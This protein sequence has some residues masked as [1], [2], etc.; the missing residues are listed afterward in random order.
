MSLDPNKRLK[1]DRFWA[2]ATGF[3]SGWA[4]M[5]LLDEGAVRSGTTTRDGRDEGLTGLFGLLASATFFGSGLLTGRLL[6]TL[7]DEEISGIDRGAGAG[8]DAGTD[9]GAGAGELATTL[10]GLDGFGGAIFF[11]GGAGL[12][13]NVELLR[14]GVNICLGD[15]IV[16]V[17]GGGE[18]LLPGIIVVA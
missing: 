6:L 5:L 18:L 1:K 12:T 3:F 7:A 10:V 15:L 17:F 11:S 16:L 8:A 2:G 14:I 9:A 13:D 4:E